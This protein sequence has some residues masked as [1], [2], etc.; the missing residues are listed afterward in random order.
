VADEQVA[1]MVYS[2]ANVSPARFALDTGTAISATL[3]CEKRK[4][5]GNV[6]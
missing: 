3:N 1:M 6:L 4:A 5:T 2:M